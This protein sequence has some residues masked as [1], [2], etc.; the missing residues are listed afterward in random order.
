[1]GIVLV[2][3]L[4][5][6]SQVSLALPYGFG[7]YAAVAILALGYWSVERLLN[8]LA[9][10]E[11]TSA[12]EPH[13]ILKPLPQMLGDFHAE[14]LPKRDLCLGDIVTFK[15][16]FKGVVEHGLFLQVD[17]TLPDGT[18]INV[19]NFDTIDRHPNWFSIPNF[20]GRIDRQFEWKWEIPETGKTGLYTFLIRAQERVPFTSKVSFK[21][22]A[23]LWLKSHWIHSIDTEVLDHPTW[24]PLHQQEFEVIVKE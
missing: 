24:S 6:N 14:L 23:L 1:M 15:V 21:L 16:T 4:I 7:P 2:I 10:K 3:I 13:P 11:K 18:K 9:G 20:R 8:F 19:P 22:H 5:V 12:V 17:I